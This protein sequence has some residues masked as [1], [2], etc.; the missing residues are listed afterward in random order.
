MLRFVA[1]GRSNKEIA[2]VLSISPRTVQHH[3]IHIYE[4]IGVESRAG[5][6][7]FAMENDLVD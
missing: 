1:R 5:A 4:K 2:I 6:A 3:T 7:L